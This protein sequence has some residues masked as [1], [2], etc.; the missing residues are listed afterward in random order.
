MAIFVVVAPSL[1]TLEIPGLLCDTQD[2]VSVYV[3][4]FSE[5]KIAISPAKICQ[6]Q[7]VP[8]AFLNNEKVL[9]LHLVVFTQHD[10]TMAGL[11]NTCKFVH[12][13]CLVKCWE[14]VQQLLASKNCHLV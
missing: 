6:L 12:F 10:C 9:R 3:N 7:P 13:L 14:L 1:F 11:K 2:S 5:G 8:T 4:Y